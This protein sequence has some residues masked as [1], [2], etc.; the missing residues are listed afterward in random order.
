MSTEFKCTKLN[1]KALEEENVYILMSHGKS[2]IYWRANCSVYCRWQSMLMKIFL[3]SEVLMSEE[4][5][6]NWRCPLNKKW[7]WLT[8]QQLLAGSR[9]YLE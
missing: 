3:V 4:L 5:T 8:L 9:D 6:L 2:R 1:Q 7:L